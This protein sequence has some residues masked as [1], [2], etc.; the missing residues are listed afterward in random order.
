[1]DEKS[2]NLFSDVAVGYVDRYGGIGHSMPIIF[3]LVQ[4]RCINI[5]EITI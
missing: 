1:M 4:L 5:A 3:I 2:T